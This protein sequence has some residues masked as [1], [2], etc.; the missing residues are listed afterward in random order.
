MGHRKQSGPRRGSLAFLPRGRASRLLPKV[1]HW[2]PYEGEPKPLA[3]VGFKA[4]MA[5]VFLSDNVPHSPT[6]GS[7]IIRPVTMVAT[8]PMFVAGLTAYSRTYSGQLRQVGAAFSEKTPEDM[9]RLIPNF[10][11]N[12]EEALKK[13]QREA[14]NIVEVRLLGM[15]QPKQASVPA[16]KPRLVEIKVGGTDVK[17]CLSFAVSRL[18]SEL[19]VSEVFSAGEFADVISVSRGKGFQGV[20]KRHGVGI[21]PRKSR[22]TRRGVAAIGAWHPAYVTYTTPRSGQMGYHR[23][24]ERGKRILGVEEDGLK[25]TPK[26]G[27]PHYGTI[28]GPCLVVDGSLAGVPKRPLIVRVA[29]RPPS[30]PYPEPEIVQVVV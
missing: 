16:K 4:G 6:F 17:E 10:K 14:E 8:P 24:T 1:K 13:I 12:G 25:V 22:K 29:A 9:R 28:K 20:V 5:H 15:T 26:G 7:E 23:R 19:S 21:L 18:G 30:S 11:A 3:F 27:F 2:P